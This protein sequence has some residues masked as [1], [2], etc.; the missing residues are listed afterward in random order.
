M[1]ITFFFLELYKLFIR[2]EGGGSGDLR[3]IA[4]MGHIHSAT[5]LGFGG[6]AASLL[7]KALRE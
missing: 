4:V 6:L 1:G 7:C 3:L 2:I 5:P